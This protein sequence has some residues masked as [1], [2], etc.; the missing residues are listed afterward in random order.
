MHNARMACIEHTT[1]DRRLGPAPR[2]LH[3]I[4]IENLIGSTRFGMG[5]V[6]A[7]AIDYRRIADFGAEDHVVLASS[8]FTA[9]PAW[10]GWPNARRLV[11]SGPHGAD[12]ALIALIQTEDIPRRFDRVVVASGRKS[13]S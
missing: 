6:A 10:C 8:H 7:V 1:R 13:S 4:D 2:T 9:L 5:A 12:L 11:R 3:L